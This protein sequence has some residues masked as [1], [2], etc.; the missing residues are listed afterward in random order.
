MSVMS[1][2]MMQSCGVSSSGKSSLTPVDSDS[3][4]PCEEE[5]Y[6]P[7]LGSNFS[8]FSGGKFFVLLPKSEQCDERLRSGSR[9]RKGCDGF[10]RPFTSCDAGLPWGGHHLSLATHLHH[11]PGTEI[12]L[13]VSATN[14]QSRF[15]F[16]LPF[17]FCLL[18]TILTAFRRNFHSLGV[19]NLRFRDPPTSARSRFRITSHDGSTSRPRNHYSSKTLVSMLM[20]AN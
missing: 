17:K 14:N 10:G 4:G 13:S 5:Q 6:G 2:S 7:D 20:Q 3:R 8:N 11:Q 16:S 9:Q 18:H 15:F 19:I 12:F 1:M